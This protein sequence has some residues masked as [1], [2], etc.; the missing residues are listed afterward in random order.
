[1]A[2]ERLL[3]N[4]GELLCAGCFARERAAATQAEIHV[5]SRRAGASAGLALLGM[6]IA[7]CMGQVDGP[8]VSFGAVG[9]IALLYIAGQILSPSRL[10][11]F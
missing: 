1:M 8:A 6:L 5:R 11:R 10:G 3:S 9:V 7:L 4:D 2:S